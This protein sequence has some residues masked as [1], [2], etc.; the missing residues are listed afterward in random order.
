MAWFEPYIDA[1]GIHVPTYDDTLS[2]LLER[3]RA[4]FG[5]DVYLGTETPDYQMLSVF[6]KCLTEFTG[7]SIDCY[8]A[9]DPNYAAGNS[10]DLVVQ[11][12]G[13]NRRVATPSEVVLKV[14]GDEGTVIAAGSK[15]VDKDG[16]VWSTKETVTIPV[17]GY[18]DVEAECDTAGSVM[19][20][21]DTITGIYTPIP[22]WFEVTN[23]LPATVGKD[24]ESDSALRERFFES[25]SASVNG[26]TDALITGLRSVSGVEYVSLVVNDTGSTV[27]S[28]P[29][30]SICALV[31]GGDD[32]EIAD[33][34]YKYKATG[35]GTYG[36][37]QKTVTD[38]Y[39]MTHTVKFTRPTEKRVSVTVT[40]VNLGG[41][42]EES[43]AEIDEI[44][45]QAILSDINGLGIGK[46]WVVTTGFRD[47]YTAFG[48]NLPF[49]VTS[50][51][52]QK[53]GGS[54]TTSTVDC[55][56]YEILYADAEHIT[57]TT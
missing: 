54:S 34:I 13:I 11:L 31:Q 14:S 1:E 19:A 35:V 21:A 32:D 51:T 46:D 45:K 20:L 17:E 4:I 18:C 2:Y 39:G 48:N 44:I 26:V 49:S 43:A 38:E 6:A 29:G 27:N 50:I 40:V 8:N 57:I 22:G 37:T 25:H 24:R 3:Y 52:A 56:Y 42:T 28:I 33:T 30:H 36:T 5:E 12:A 7:L 16:Y 53:E 55:E 9:R 23:E 10:L 47:I 15:A 41:Y